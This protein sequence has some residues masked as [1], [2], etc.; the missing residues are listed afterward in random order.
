[1][2]ATAEGDEIILKF[3][4]NIQIHTGTGADNVLTESNIIVLVHALQNCTFKVPISPD[5]FKEAHP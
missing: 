5:N 3:Y 2:S 1:M 4:R